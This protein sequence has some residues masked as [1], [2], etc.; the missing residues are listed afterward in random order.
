MSG[1]FLDILGPEAPHW[2]QKMRRRRFARDEVIFHEGELGDTLHVLEKGRVL[3]E[4]TTAGGNVAALSVRGPGELLGEIA[5][6]GGGRRT[7]RVTALEPTETLTLDNETLEDLRRAEPRVD[8]YLAELLV[9]KLAET[10]AQLMEV[11][12]VPVEKR[13]FRVLDRLTTRF[14]TGE[15]PIVIRLRQ[16]DIA[17]MAGTRRQTANRPLKSAEARGILRIGRGRIEIVDRAAVSALA[18]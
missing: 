18:R 2:R 13:I 15:A 8:R 1:G 9:A 6:V 16:E 12:F 11:L 4:V 5:I 14:D 10:T 17:A 7:A 3:V